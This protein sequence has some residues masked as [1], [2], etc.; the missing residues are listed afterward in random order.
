[1]CGPDV[2]DVYE[3][4]GGTWTLTMPGLC[5]GAPPPLAESCRSPETATVPGARLWLSRDAAGAPELVDGDLVEIVFG[6]QGLAMIPYRIHVDAETPPRCAHITVTLGMEGMAGT[7]VTHDVRLR[8]GGSL[9]IQDI[10]AELPC[11][12]REYAIRL[13]VT[14]E[15]V[16]SV[17]LELRAMGG[18]CPLGG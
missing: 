7:P 6:S 17:S 12:E 15:G 16:G 14:V 10:L 13:E 8:C 3:C 1:M 18:G 4:V 5:A 11:E 9:R 2:R